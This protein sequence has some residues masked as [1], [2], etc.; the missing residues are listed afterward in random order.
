MNPLECGKNQPAEFT[1]YVVFA[2]LKQ[3][4]CPLQFI[5]RIDAKG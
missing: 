3:L 2:E 5:L 4:A 1:A